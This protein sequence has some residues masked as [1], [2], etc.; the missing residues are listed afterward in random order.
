MPKKGKKKAK[1]TE[2]D[3][4]LEAMPNIEIIYED[5]KVVTGAGSEF[6]WG[7]LYPMIKYQKVLDAVLE[8]IPLYE[9]ILRSGITKVS[10]RP[11]LFL[12]AEVISWILPK[13]EA[14]D[15]I[16]YNVEGKGFA[17]FTP[18]YISKAYSLLAPEVSMMND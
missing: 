15:M 18:T 12:C 13:A 17:S 2:E 10:T 5:T 9:N 4:D 3:L 7:Q 1:A 11:E 6:K 14:S 8:D 16:M